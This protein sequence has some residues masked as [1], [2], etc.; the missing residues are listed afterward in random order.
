MLAHTLLMPEMNFETTA[1]FICWC[2][3][4]TSVWG[5]RW[6]KTSVSACTPQQQTERSPCQGKCEHENFICHQ[7]VSHCVRRAVGARGTLWKQ[8]HVSWCGKWAATVRRRSPQPTRFLRRPHNVA[9][10]AGED[11][12]EKDFWDSSMENKISTWKKIEK[13]FKMAVCPQCDAA[14]LTSQL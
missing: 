12:P 6:K 7:M 5:P 10:S 11:L 1:A 4:A 8:Q 13:I 2:D 9:T 14:R 3:V